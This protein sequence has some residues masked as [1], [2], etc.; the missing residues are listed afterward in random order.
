VLVLDGD[1]GGAARRGRGEDCYVF[2]DDGNDGEL[3][4]RQGNECK[5]DFGRSQ[6]QP[7]RWREKALAQSGK[8]KGT[9]KRLFSVRIFFRFDHGPRIPRPIPAKYRNRHRALA[10][11]VLTDSFEDGARE[12]LKWAGTRVLVS[13]RQFGESFGGF[14]R[15]TIIYEDSE[16][17]FTDR[18]S[19]V[20]WSKNN[21]DLFKEI[22]ARVEH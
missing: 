8:G 9:P 18:D 20:D 17:T 4:P 16:Y 1:A 15:L 10:V 14:V 13:Q 6:S 21:G 12:T 3:P 19:I 11:L 2:A 7:M 22:K 5:R